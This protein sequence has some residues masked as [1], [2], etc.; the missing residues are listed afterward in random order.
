[1]KLTYNEIMDKLKEDLG[2]VD[3]LAFSGIMNIEVP[4]EFMPVADDR[5]WQAL[6]E[7]TVEY[8]ASL[9]YGRVEQVDSYGGEGQG[10]TWY[11]IWHFQDHGI[12]IQV[13]GY[14]QSYHGT[15]FYDGWD[16]CKQVEPKQRTVTVYENV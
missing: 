12:Y 14:Y 1:M 9:G 11:S 8:A 10:E 16:S 3:D 13:D 6:R 4:E 7:R 5:D 15:E 2:R